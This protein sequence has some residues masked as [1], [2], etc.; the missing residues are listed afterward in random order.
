MNSMKSIVVLGD[1]MLDIFHH[2]TSNRLNPESSAPLLTID[3]TEFKIWWAWNVANNLAELGV[4][5]ILIGAVGKDVYAKEL[6]DLLKYWR[7]ELAQVEASENTTVKVRLIDHRVSYWQAARFDINGHAK[8]KEHHKEYIIKTILDSKCEYVIVS[9]YEKWMVTK[10]LIDLVLQAWKKAGFKVIADAKP[11]HIEFFEN[12]FLIKPNFKEFEDIIGQQIPNEDKDIK[13][14]GIALAKRLNT[15]VLI[16][17]WPQWASFISKT[18]KCEHLKTEAKAVFDVTGAGDTFIAVLTYW[19]SAG[20]DIIDAIK[21]G[22]K[23]AGIS[24]G[25]TGTAVVTKKELW[26]EIEPYMWS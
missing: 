9:D 20:M 25:K 8:L 12:C 15:N 7:I 13:L 26:L 11:N 5:T 21:L 22:N 17:R 18:G 16:T 10:E 4:H 6:R 23:A 14:H 1:V 3:R 2:G 19:L 24:V